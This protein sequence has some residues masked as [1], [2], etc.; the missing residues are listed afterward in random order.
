MSLRVSVVASAR[1]RKELLDRFRKDY[2]EKP[3]DE[4]RVLDYA[5]VL[6]AAEKHTEAVKVLV[7]SADVLPKSA[8]V[9][10][11]ATELLESLGDYPATKSFLERRLEEEP[12]RSDLRFKLVKA[13]YA[14][15][16]DADADQEFRTVVA[17]LQPEEASEKI[18]ELQRFLR[19]IV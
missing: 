4:G 5:E 7:T 1:Q 11:R 15:G 2:E 3:E 17:G 14:L 8:R 19:S 10:A 13:D 18:M 9:E 12:E 16:N 6:V